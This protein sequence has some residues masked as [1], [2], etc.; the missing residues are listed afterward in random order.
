MR[1]TTT[2]SPGLCRPL[3]VLMCLLL[4]V[5]ASPAPDAVLA[6]QSEAPPVG[7]AVV[8][9]GETAPGF[10]S[11]F[12]CT[13]GR[14]SAQREPEGLTFR[15]RGRCFEEYPQAGSHA[16]SHGVSFIDGDISLEMQVVEG[17]DR[18]YFVLDGRVS[19]NGTG[20][21]VLWYPAGGVAQLTV[22]GEEDDEP[23]VLAR[24]TGLDVPAVGTWTRLS[25]RFQD[26]RIWALMDGKVVMFATDST[27]ERGGVALG[28][29]RRPK[30]LPGDQAGDDDEPFSDIWSDIQLAD[31]E[32]VAIV[33][34]DLRISALANGPASRAPVLRVDAPE[35]P[36]G[37][38]VVS[39]PGT[40]PRLGDVI[41]ADALDSS[42]LVPNSTC[43]SRRGSVVTVGEGLMLK[44]TG[45]CTPSA[46]PGWAHAALPGLTVPD[47]ELRVEYKVTNGHQQ[48]M[49][50]IAARFVNE[51]RTYYFMVV[52]ATGVAAI[53]KQASSERSMLTR[54]TDLRPVTARDGAWQQLAV[55]LHGHELWLLIDDL[56]VL[57]ATDDAV[58]GGQAVLLTDRFGDRN[59]GQEIAVV[60]RNLQ[61]SA[62]ADSADNRRPV[63][64]RR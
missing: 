23:V 13:T 34:R 40:P 19:P 43:P 6:S 57:R 3:T 33:V 16:W 35:Q 51:Y 47:G 28:A 18:A 46:M 29:I 44:S 12:N 64:V 36:R 37:V 26:T 15:V 10:L 30:L 20:Y 52:P 9:D 42:S 63:H 53:M 25:L 39:A 41:L 55:R 56:P 32:S 8:V 58:D 54:R 1:R 21:S 14:G 17:Q 62:L 48:A 2:A 11:S 22:V 38:G 61:V 45:P 50:G 59:D 4:M 7:A 49:V 60:F 27:Q 24:A 31:E 5:Q